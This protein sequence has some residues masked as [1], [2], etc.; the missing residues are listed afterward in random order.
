MDIVNGS[1]GQEI[2]RHPNMSRPKRLEQ[3]DTPRKLSSTGDRRDRHKTKE[4]KH[5]LN[6]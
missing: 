6:L 4:C 1:E 5:F 3:R 2:R